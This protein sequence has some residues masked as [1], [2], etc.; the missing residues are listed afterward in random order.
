MKRRER[1]LTTLQHQEPDRVPVGFDMHPDIERQVCEYYGVADLEGLY[2][3]IGIECFSV[4]H[5]AWSALPVYI[6]P[7]RS[8]VP[9]AD[10]TYGC[11]GKYPEH[12]YPLAVD[13][14]DHYRWLTVEDFDFSHLRADLQ[15][16]RD[17]DHIVGSGH[18]G[19]GWLH[20]VQM[21]GYDLSLM[22]VLDDGWMRNYLAHNRAFLVPYFERLFQ[23]TGGLIDVIRADEDLG[24]H[25]AMLISPRLWRKW[26]KPLWAEIFEICHR[27][28]AKIW[29][30][31]CGFCRSVVD[32]FIEAGADVLNPV[33]AYVRGSDPLEMK[34]VYGER[35]CFDGG[36]DQ[37]RVLVGGS[38]EA[39]R[40]EV[41][42]RIEQM[43]PGGGYI[44]GPS[45]VLTNDIPLENLVAM[46]DAVN[47][48][49]WYAHP[50]S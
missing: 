44:L 45:Q 19:A 27:N 21:R 49:G 36:V 22:D 15:A 33:P 43:A 8:G 31:S 47:E 5:P 7:A 11:W 18:A 41:R 4:W 2:T 24:G 3:K 14:M 34:Q 32:D 46:F 28:G 39:V 25:E 16:I 37:M 50:G 17:S 30:H 23:E 38:P 26:Y 48:F 1:I 6:G 9:T 40:Q 12:I 35:L 10:S 42:L 13:D 20:H 29:L